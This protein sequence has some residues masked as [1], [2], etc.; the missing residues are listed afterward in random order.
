MKA[1]RRAN[2]T[3]RTR[4]A[5]IALLIGIFASGTALLALPAAM[6]LAPPCSLER[7][8]RNVT[9]PFGPWRERSEQRIT[10]GHFTPYLS[11]EFQFRHAIFKH[12]W[13]GKTGRDFLTQA[14]LSGR[15]MN[16]PMSFKVG[17][18][19]SGNTLFR[20]I[21]GGSWTYP[22]GRRLSTTLEA[23]RLATHDLGDDANKPG[24]F[25]GR[26][27]YRFNEQTT[28][29]V[30]SEQEW[31]DRYS[32]AQ[33]GYVID[34]L[35]LIGEYR[36]SGATDTWRMGMQYY[37][38]KCVDLTADY[39]LNYNDATNSGVGRATAG[40][41]SGQMYFESSVGGRFFFDKE[42]I[43]DSTFYEGNVTWGNTRLG[44]SSAGLGYTVESG[45]ASVSRTISGTVERV[46][47]RRTRIGLTLAE[48]RFD[49]GKTNVQNMESRLH[50]RVDWGFYE[51]RFALISGGADSNLEKDI[52]LRAGYEF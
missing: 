21:D 39:R 44:E 19:W 23:G 14:S 35:R 11:S 36:S 33:L 8:E 9:T 28:F 18:I 15:N 5:A 10:Y 1:H 52:A 43:P 51:L 40:F 42:K 7:T 17:R 48:T 32:A 16:S 37:D 50:R 20:S 45:V 46:V 6:Q 49:Q 38:G 47:T 25:E 31:R 34:A 30:L 26:L 3:P 12:E 27:N 22:W 2:G 41:E 29:T 24:Y 13:G 4:W